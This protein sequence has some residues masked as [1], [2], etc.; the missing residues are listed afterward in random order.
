MNIII[1]VLNYFVLSSNGARYVPLLVTESRHEDSSRDGSE[2][3]IG[4]TAGG[5][6][7]LEGAADSTDSGPL[8][9]CNVRIQSLIVGKYKSCKRY[10]SNSLKDRQGCLIFVCTVNHEGHQ[11]SSGISR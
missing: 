9:K 4:A 11:K 7:T 10:A 2:A 5:G 6:A 1:F 8:V 3:A